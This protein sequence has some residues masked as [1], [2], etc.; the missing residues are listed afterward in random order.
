[1]IKRQ[2][3]LEIYRDNKKEWRWKIIAS[4]GNILA[5]CSEGY[6]RKAGLKTGLKAIVNF[7]EYNL[8]FNRM[9]EIFN[10]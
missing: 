2:S 1:M 5:E 10:Q 7:F 8:K 4:N 6:K 3:K 9:K